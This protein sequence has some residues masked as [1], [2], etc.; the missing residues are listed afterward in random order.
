[1]KFVTATPELMRKFYGHDQYKTIQ[2]GFVVVDGDEPLAVGG[3]IR[4]G[5]DKRFIFVDSNEEARKK[6][7]VTTLKFAKMLVKVAEDEGWTLYAFPED[8][9]EE[10]EKTLL[11]L[12][13]SYDEE[14]ELYVK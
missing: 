11:H 4:Y 7:K 5:K 9:I 2:R 10:A 8:S 12:G 13:F 1:M 6:N 3:F 14:Q